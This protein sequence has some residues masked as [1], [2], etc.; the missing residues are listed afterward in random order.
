M[1]QCHIL[2]NRYN[3]N[4]DQQILG[5]LQHDS[6]QLKNKKPLFKVVKE[7]VSETL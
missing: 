5:I 1:L 7:G 3:Y 6:N 4:T 2:D